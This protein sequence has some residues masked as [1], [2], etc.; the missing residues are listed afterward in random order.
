M[1]QLFNS[2]A[3]CACGDHVDD[4]NKEQHPFFHRLC[5]DHIVQISCDILEAPSQPINLKF[6]DLSSQKKTNSTQSCRRRGFQYAVLTTP[7]F[8]VR[9]G[10]HMFQGR[11]C[12]QG[13]CHR[14]Y[15]AKI[16]LEFAT[17]HANKVVQSC[18]D[19]CILSRFRTCKDITKRVIAERWL[20]VRRFETRQITTLEYCQRSLQYSDSFRYPDGRAHPTD[21]KK[22]MPFV[23]ISL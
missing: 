18:M 14:P 22:R 6:D 15:M 13:P 7:S 1:T 4:A 2:S 23:H 5:C 17:F 16:V 9:R 19:L 11:K 8:R 21:G 20:L 3:F 12:K 10:I